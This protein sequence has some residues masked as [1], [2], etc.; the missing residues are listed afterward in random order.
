[1][2]TF[3]DLFYACCDELSDISFIEALYR[4][5]ARATESIRKLGSFC[6]K[7]ARSLLDTIMGEALAYVNLSKNTLALN[8]C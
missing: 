1:S 4:I 3:G 6:E 7:T 5:L 8:E 2:R